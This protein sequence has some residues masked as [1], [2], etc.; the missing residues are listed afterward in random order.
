VAMGGA[1]GSDEG[2]KD[3]DGSVPATDTSSGKAPTDMDSSDGGDGGGG[4]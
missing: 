2:K 1:M 3:V 4:D